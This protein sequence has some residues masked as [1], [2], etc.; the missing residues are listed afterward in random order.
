MLSELPLDTV[1]ATL[2]PPRIA[3]E[4]R[5]PEPMPEPLVPSVFAR[6]P[7][8]EGN[9]GRFRCVDCGALS[10]DTSALDEI[11]GGLTIKFGWRLRRRVDAEGRTIVEPRCARCHA[12]T[13]SSGVLGKMA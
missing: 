1:A 6:R 4:R 7:V 2:P 5:L 12:R 3:D 8:L 13:K 10:P 9:E 11:S